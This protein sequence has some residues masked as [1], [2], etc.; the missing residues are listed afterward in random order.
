MLFL[1]RKTRSRKLD[2]LK[3]LA[4]LNHLPYNACNSF[5]GMA[6]LV[7]APDSKSGDGDIVPVRFR[8]SVPNE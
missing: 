2:S 5:A 7:D 4:L 1:T 8:L 6:E 3:K